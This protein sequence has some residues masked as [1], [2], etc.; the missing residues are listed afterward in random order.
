MQIIRI[1]R[2]INND[3]VIQDS[4]VGRN[5]LELIVENGI[6]KVRDLQSRNGTF[7]NGRR[8]ENETR[9]FPGDTLLIGKTVLPWQQYISALPV[10]DE[11]RRQQY[12]IRR[13]WWMVGIIGSVSSFIGLI[14]TLLML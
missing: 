3:V 5:H 13:M 9:L 1:G 7:V 11:N 2:D 12:K 10:N 8:I 6:T 4:Y 14:L